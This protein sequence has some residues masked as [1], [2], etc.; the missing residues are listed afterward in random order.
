VSLY[1]SY[2]INNDPGQGSLAVTRLQDIYSSYPMRF[3]T[4]EARLTI[5]LNRNIDWNLGYQY[6]SYKET[7]IQN[8]LVFIVITGQPNVNQVYPAQNYTAHLP[9]TS[10]RI[11]FGGD[12]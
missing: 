12:R 4:P 11:Y 5:K 10:L 2:R 6:Y 3:Q 9:Y 7:P 8:P 1:A